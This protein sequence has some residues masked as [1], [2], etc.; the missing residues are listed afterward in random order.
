VLKVGE[1]EVEAMVEVAEGVVVDVA[2]GVVGEVQ[3]K[4]L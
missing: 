4:E 3:E 2:E 1:E